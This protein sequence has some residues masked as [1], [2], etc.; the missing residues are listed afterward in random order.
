MIH[1]FVFRLAHMW[2]HIASP[3]TRSQCF[4]SNLLTLIKSKVTVVQPSIQIALTVQPIV[5]DTCILFAVCAHF[6]NAIFCILYCC[7]SSDEERS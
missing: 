6:Y 2:F 7:F 4:G 3:M 5:V 1:D